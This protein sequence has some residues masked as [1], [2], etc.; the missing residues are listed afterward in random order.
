MI[1]RRDEPG[2]GSWGRNVLSWLRP[3]APHRL[4]LRYEELVREPTDA[5]QRIVVALV[6]QLL[7]L[8]DVRIPSFG[9]LRQTDRRFFRRGRTD[10]YRDELPELPGR[11]SRRSP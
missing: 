7:P 8:T 4:V 5:V 9:E 6:P 1:T 11:L 10:T 2:T 3:P